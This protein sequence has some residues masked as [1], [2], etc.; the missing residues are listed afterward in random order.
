METHYQYK[1]VYGIGSIMYLYSI[2][3]KKGGLIRLE[4]GIKCI[5]PVKILI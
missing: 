4:C 2:M 5:K 1:F 3:F